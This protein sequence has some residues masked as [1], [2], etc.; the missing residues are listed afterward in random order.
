MLN[1]EA[2]IRPYIENGRTI[3][4]QIKWLRRKGIH[5]YAVEK[6]IL[7]IYTGMQLGKV[8][9]DGNELDQA[10]LQR[11]IELVDE[12]TALILQRLSQVSIPGGRISKAWAALKGEI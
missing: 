6:A 5:P 3:E 4:G 1:F 2:L 8:Y 10:L 11:G 9:Q 7:D 12:E